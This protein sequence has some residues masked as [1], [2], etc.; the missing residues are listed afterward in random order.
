MIKRNC[1]ACGVEFI[2]EIKKGVNIRKKFCSTKCRSKVYYNKYYTHFKWRKIKKCEICGIEYMPQKSISFTCSRKC[3]TKRNR[4]LHKEAKRKYD[5][6][7]QKNDRKNNP[8]KYRLRTKE[9]RYKIREASNGT[10]CKKFNRVFSLEIWEKLKHEY[11]YTCPKCLKVEPEI[12][13]TID[14]I[15]PLSKGGI[16]SIENIQPLCHSCNSG[17]KDKYEF[18]PARNT[19]QETVTV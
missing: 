16:H 19:G 5:K 1:V 11:N 12:K 13:L 10:S 2:I 6:K 3:C 15:L 7:W 8:E 18:Y 14:H 9:R 17:K 4:I